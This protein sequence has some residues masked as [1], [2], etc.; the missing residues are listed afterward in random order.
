L[1]NL[2]IG[3]KLTLE[4]TQGEALAMNVSLTRELEHFVNQKVTSG[5]YHSASEVV[6]EGLRL[7]KEKEDLKKLRLDEL[8]REIAIGVEQ[9]D[10]G[11]YEEYDENGLK[12]LVQEGQSEGRKRLAHKGKP[13]HK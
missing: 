2:V 5:L 6:R 13:G 10:R 9:L 8:R 3:I 12:E 1:T 11:E 7:L 4:T